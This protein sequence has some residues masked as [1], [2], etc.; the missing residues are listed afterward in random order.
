LRVFE[1]LQWHATSNQ[2]PLS[3]SL[4]RAV[5]GLQIDGL[6]KGSRDL[7]GSRSL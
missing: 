3:E 2:C 5:R 1:I 7:H 4:P 6:G